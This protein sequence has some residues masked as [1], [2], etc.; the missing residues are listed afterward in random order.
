MKTLKKFTAVFLSALT[1]M[2]LCIIPSFA[3]AENDKIKFAVA[4]D[5]HLKL[6]DA[7]VP[8][9][10]PESELYYHADS[11][12]NLNFEAAGIVKSAL[13]KAE[14]N[15]VDFVMMS[16]D[17]AHNGREDQHR[18][19]ASLLEDFQNES[20]IP[21]YIV[22]G[23]HDYYDSGVDD[24]KQYY[25]N[26]GL[27]KAIAVDSE[28]FSYT[29]DLSDKYRLIAIDSNDPG[30]DGDG[31]DDRLF[32]WIETQAKAAAADGKTIIATMHHPLLEP[33][34][35]AHILMKD[36]IVRNYE[37]V[38]E[39]FAQWGIQYVFTG[40]EHGNNITSFTGSNGKVVYDILSTA[41]TSYPLEF[42]MVDMSSS[43]VEISME[44]VTEADFDYIPASYNDA[45]RELIKKD[46]T[47]YSLGYFKYSVAKKIDRVIAPES[48]KRMLKAD[49]GVLADA[50]DTV[51]PIVID[52]LDMPL[53]EKDTDGVSVE[54]L[55]A[56]AGAKLP[57]SDYES[58][59]DVITTV[60]A[61]IYRGNE[62][63]PTSTSPEGK[64]V[65]IALN[66]LLKYVLSKTGN[67]VTTD[68]L[69]KIA[70]VF[71]LDRVEYVDLY[72]WNRALV[73]GADNSYEIATAVL[74]P[75][76]DKFLLD[77]GIPDR[78]AVLGGPGTTEAKAPLFETFLL[79]IKEFF[80]YIFSIFNAALIFPFNC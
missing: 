54:K 68:S 25:A 41:L 52:A 28:T 37:D 13:E 77:D 55:A 42:R 21:V 62:D 70:S 36:F 69:N 22:P 8:V 4:T 67:R 43:K 74:A 53:Y 39:K 46:Y 57:E 56:S 47:A 17:F 72:K 3:G 75:L 23:N 18:F 73:L 14:K 66:T 65:I 61:V 48:L 38:A 60:V 33:I 27:D 15:G 31:I 40:H 10:Y 1:V 59:M 79:R 76:L 44:R 20:G 58:L 11:S 32:S 30:D 49:S 12:G 50:V 7:E 63:I 5:I 2:L 29:A 80:R 24:L 71:G 19:F 9:N 51:M 64:I 35:Y 26:L 34:P 6:P 45:Q 78:N 16:G